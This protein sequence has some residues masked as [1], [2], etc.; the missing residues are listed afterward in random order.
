MLSQLSFAVVR[1]ASRQI[2]AGGPRSLH[3]IPLSPKKQSSQKLSARRSPQL[4]LATLQ[5]VGSRCQPAHAVVRAAT[6]TKHEPGLSPS[7]RVVSYGSAMEVWALLMRLLS[8]YQRARSEVFA[9]VPLWRPALT[10]WLSVAMCA[11]AA[12]LFFSLCARRNT[13]CRTRTCQFFRRPSELSPRTK[14]LRDNRKRII[15]ARISFPARAAIVPLLGWLPSCVHHDF[16][17]S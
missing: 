2:R 17:Q 1:D 4:V 12:K 13:Y 16:L 8:R 10:R 3:R 9:V 14:W 11:A 5:G 15:S 6:A 7:N